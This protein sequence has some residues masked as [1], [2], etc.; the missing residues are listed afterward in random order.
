MCQNAAAKAPGCLYLV[1][2]PIGNLEDITLRSLR[3]LREV[4][5]IAC[6]DTR[7]TAKLLAHYGI[8][9]RTMSY[10]EHTERSKA[11]QLAR[12]LEDGKSIALVSEAGT[13]LL[14]D[15]GYHL[16]QE[17]LRLG[18]PVVP[19][20]GPSSIL[21]G[22]TASG[23]PTHRFAFLGFAPRKPGKLRNFLSRYRG[24]DGSLVLFEA[25]GRVARLLEAVAEVFG[26]ETPVAVCRELTKIHEELKRGSAASLAHLLHQHTPKGELTV[27]VA[28]SY[29][30][31]SAAGDTKG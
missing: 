17:A 26:A 23:L 14:S 27:V 6:E 25:P 15:P 2:T 18:V 4:D 8:Q 28:P 5:L 10:Q 31:Q 7:T 30:G 9:V 21:A 29:G 12:L 19:V 16:V 13:P 22:L 24:F 20:P 11:P 3:I 1:A